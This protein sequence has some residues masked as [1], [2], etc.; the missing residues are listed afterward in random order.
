MKLRKFWS[1]NT[2]QHQYLR[3]K[4]YK[5]QQLAK[6]ANGRATPEYEADT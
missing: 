1:K 6:F 2:S 4:T 3:A 5:N